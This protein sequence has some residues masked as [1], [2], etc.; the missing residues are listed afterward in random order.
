MQTIKL[1]Y[2]TNDKETILAY[3]KQYTSCL[4]FMFNR[5]L[6]GVQETQIKHLSINHVDLLDSWFKQS[7]VKEALQLASTSKDRKVIFGGRYNFI[8]RCKNLLTKE[9]FQ[10]KRLSPLCSIG[11]GSNP[12]V[13]GNRKFHLENDLRTVTFK[14]N[15]KTRVEL[16]LPNIR[17]NLQRVLSKLYLKQQ[18]S[19]MSISYKLSQDFIFISFDERDIANEPVKT[20]TNRVL[21]L[22]LNPNY[23]GWSI[24][25]WTSESTFN[26]IDSG[27]Y[28]LKN[29][30]DTE[31]KLKQLKLSSDHPKRV[32]LSDKRKFETL[33]ISK[34]LFTKALHYHVEIVAVE[35]LSISSSNKNLGKHFNKLCNNFWLRNLI[36]NNL[37][38]RCNLFGIRFQIVK[39]EYS[40]FIGNILY[41]DL[42]LPDMVLSSI[43]ISRRAY[44]FSLQYIKKVKN[45]KKNIVFPDLKLFQDRLIKSLEELDQKIEVKD[46]KELYCFLKNSKVRYRVPLDNWSKVF[47]LKCIK[48]K[49][50]CYSFA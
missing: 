21:A 25:D 40:S 30:N 17:P 22:D 14:P 6:D 13:R 32:H 19:S 1:P 11:E 27:V 34:D 5:V 2:K 49:V 42:A 24:T 9:E 33:E 35:S 7:C 12:S 39:P 4:H 46:L 20:V 47:S 36:A 15:R 16:E 43:E 50:E 18:S 48:S 10:L 44:E 26:V 45:I 31:R 8:Q 23:V 38:K 41:R 37:S 29:L 28:S 3:I